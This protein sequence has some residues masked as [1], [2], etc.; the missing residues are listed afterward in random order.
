[1]RTAVLLLLVSTLVGCSALEGPPCTL[2]GSVDG[3][4][5]DFAPD[6]QLVSGSLAITVCDDHDCASFEDHWARRSRIGGLPGLTATFD[7]LGRSFEP[8]SVHVTTELRDEAGTLVAQRAQDVE[9]SR[10]HPNGK[11][12][13]GDGWVNGSLTLTREDAVVVPS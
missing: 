13:D 9:L 4:S 11:D 3:V 10:V 7:D 8:G 1:M 2:I 6:L 12:C 5:V